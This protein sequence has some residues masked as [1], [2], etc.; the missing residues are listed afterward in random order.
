MIAWAYYGLG[1][2]RRLRVLAAGEA[3]EAGGD[4]QYQVAR[5]REV[6]QPRR[7]KKRRLAAR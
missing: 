1:P 7:E 6:E 2:Q 5:R 4:R 3:P